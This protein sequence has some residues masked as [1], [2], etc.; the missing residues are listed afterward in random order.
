MDD[1][2]WNLIK[3][4]TD[5]DFDSAV[6]FLNSEYKKDNGS[7][8]TRESL[9][10][11]LG[12]YNP[13]GKGVMF[14]AVLNNVTVGTLSLTL[15][16]FYSDGKNILVGELGDGY[17][18][19]IIYK[20]TPIRH[21]ECNGQY[22]GGEKNRYYIQ[23][24]IAGRLCAEI[25]DWAVENNV[26]FIYG[27]PNDLAIKSW[28]NRMN[29]E[30]LDFNNF[31]KQVLLTKQ[32][33]QKKIK[34]NHLSSALIGNVLDK[35]NYFLLFYE[36]LNLRNYQI[37]EVKSDND[38]LANDCNQLWATYRKYSDNEIVRNKLWLN[39]RYIN[40]TETT[41]KVFTLRDADNLLGWCVIKIDK[42]GNYKNI[43]ICDSVF[44]T[45][46]KIW[47]AFIFII[48]RKLDYQN[49]VVLFWSS[50]N[51]SLSNLF[52]K[53]AYGKVNIVCRIINRYYTIDNLKLNQF[54]LGHSDNV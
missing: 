45:N 54:F 26:N 41:Y 2:K 19:K 3:C 32:L 16:I 23:K 30:V 33:F 14:C 35:L 22:N 44:N 7:L 8:W 11:K 38:L 31:R 50:G 5:N 48:L 37:I 29:F 18:S 10:W 12:S 20:K 27:V 46:T 36:I 47:N 17:T 39:W 4:E 1:S 15:K 49:S 40:S 21:Y 24:S 28:C 34:L 6:K 42:I 52:G 13:A 53:Y 9:Q 51:K 43:S 25:I